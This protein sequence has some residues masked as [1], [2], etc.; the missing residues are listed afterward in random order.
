MLTAIAKYRKGIIAAI[1]AGLTWATTAFPSFIWIGL[2]AAVL[3]AVGV[4][5]VPNDSE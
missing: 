1:G 2:I 4:Y 3:T 5:Q